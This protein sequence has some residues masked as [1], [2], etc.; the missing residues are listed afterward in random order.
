MILLTIYLTLFFELL[1]IIGRMTF[2]SVTKLCRKNKI[3][4]IHHGYIGLLLAVV[5]LFY[6]NELI[7]ALGTSLGASDLIHHFVFL[8]LWYKKLK[9]S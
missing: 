3:P 9:F 2:G 6:F 5:C 4:H 7:L 8:P 1:A